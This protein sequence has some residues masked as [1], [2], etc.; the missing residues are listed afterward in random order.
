MRFSSLLSFPLSASA[1]L[2]STSLA[3]SLSA[4]LFVSTA[5]ADDTVASEDDDFFKSDD[6]PK[7]PDVPDASA[8]NSGDD[9]AI[10]IAAPI[11]VE[12]PAPKPA[13]VGPSRLG[14]DLNGK[15]PL[16]DNWAPAVVFTT[17]DSVVVELPVLYANNGAGFDGNAYWLIGEVYA[18]GKKLGEQRTQVMKE[19]VSAKGASVQ[20]FRFFTPVS[21]PSGVLEIKVSKLAA[22]ASKP[23]LLFTRS[24][25]YAL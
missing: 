5:R 20:F 2:L 8:F 15:S 19:T 22:G 14:L 7:P 13:P 4:S 3:A 18:D 1:L 16:T 24:V 6:K 11:K 9:D 25:S 10:S 12:P 21:E 23:G 17:V